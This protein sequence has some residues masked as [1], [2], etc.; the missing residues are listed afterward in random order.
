MVTCHLQLREA[1]NNGVVPQGPGALLVDVELC[2]C[3]SASV[4]V[5]VTSCPVL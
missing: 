4:A 1:D 3:P 2:T 5:V